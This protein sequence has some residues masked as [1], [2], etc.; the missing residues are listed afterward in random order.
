MRLSKKIVLLLKFTI[1][2]MIRGVPEYKRIFR[3]EVP[4]ARTVLSQFNFNREKIR[5]VESSWWLSHT[6][7]RYSNGTCTIEELLFRVNDFINRYQARSKAVERQR[8]RTM[9]V[10]HDKQLNPE[11][12]NEL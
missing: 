11:K 10:P 8:K 2:P 7:R 6:F 1:K 12:D 5:I 3:V 9:L 4:I